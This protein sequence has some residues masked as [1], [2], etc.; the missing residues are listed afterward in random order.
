MYLYKPDTLT[1]FSG[2]PPIYHV[3]NGLYEYILSSRERQYVSIGSG[4]GLLP[5]GNK[6]LPEPKLTKIHNAI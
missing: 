3:I 1:Y 4:N 2:K 6:P 5:S